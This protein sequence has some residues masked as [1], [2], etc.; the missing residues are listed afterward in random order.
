MNYLAHLYLSPEQEDIKLGS[1]LGDF[2][3]GP[4]KDD[5]TLVNRAII[6]H[7]KLDTFT[8]NNTIV[9]R[10]KA[11]IKN[12]QRRYAGVI[13]DIFY[14]YFLAKNWSSFH[15]SPLASYSQ[16][17]YEI[18]AKRQSDLPPTLQTILPKMIQNDWL[19]SYA[20]EHKLENLLKQV[21]LRFKRSVALEKCFVDLL[22]NYSDLENDFFSFMP[23]ARQF[24]QSYSE[25]YF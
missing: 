9:K 15:P 10:S 8:D 5:G 3:K 12:A 7:R 1:L 24:C 25:T 19:S 13:I 11:H 4:V 16:K 20:H 18:L 22:D 17:I 2:I 23:L 6:L 21:G 14:D